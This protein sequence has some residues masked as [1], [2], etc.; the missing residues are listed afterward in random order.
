MRR[1][2]GQH[3]APSKSKDRRQSPAYRLRPGRESS[4]RVPHKERKRKSSS[5]R[6][7]RHLSGHRHK[8][9]HRSRTRSRSRQRGRRDESHK[10]V[11]Q[12]HLEESHNSSLPER[13]H[14]ASE[15]PVWSPSSSELGA[16]QAACSGDLSLHLPDED[17]LL[18]LSKPI[19]DAEPGAEETHAEGTSRA[20]ESPKPTDKMLCS[21]HDRY[22]TC[23]NL[24]RCE[25]DP[26][27]WMCNPDNPCLLPGQKPVSSKERPSKARIVPKREHASSN[28]RRLGVQ[29]TLG[30]QKKI[31][32]FALR[33]AAARRP[34]VSAPSSRRQDAKAATK[35]LVLCVL[36]N[37]LRHPDRMARKGN[38]DW[39]CTGDDRCKGLAE[40][41]RQ[42]TSALRL[43]AAPGSQ[44]RSRPLLQSSRARSRPPP[45]LSSGATISSANSIPL[46]GAKQSVSLRQAQPAI[47]DRKRSRTPQRPSDKPPLKQGMA[48]CSV[49]NKPRL[50][51]RLEKRGKDWVCKPSARCR[52]V[53]GESQ[54]RQ[55]APSSQHAGAERRLPSTA[56][57]RCAVHD[58]M[59]TAGNME[60]RRDGS[61]VCKPSCKCVDA[62]V[63]AEGKSA[64]SKCTRA[65]RRLPSSAKVRCVV[66]D[67]MRTAGNMERRRDGSW[68]CKPGCKCADRNDRRD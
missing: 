49:H 14:E 47:A 64:P 62:N 40:E 12:E 37:K 10:S 2:A 55:P 18:D 68:A 44:E 29:R 13:K 51:D 57:V 17:G 26:T 65:E 43:T 4:S 16:E 58:R 28:K 31:G 27:K 52:N 8:R 41:P 54:S 67:R 61:W 34:L 50:L 46:G 30:P 35:G 6:S 11:T 24:Q 32:R 42:S 63:R 25:T 21:L 36:H 9:G 33:A 7:R 45:R 22:R 20:S 59:R 48:F 1:S 66:H 38:G 15:E 56:T 23:R 19:L 5:P 60:Q 39:V 3:K 53:D